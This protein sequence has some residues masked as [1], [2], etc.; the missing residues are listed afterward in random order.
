MCL[1]M[2]WRRKAEEGG[3]VG[4]MEERMFPAGFGGHIRLSVNTLVVHGHVGNGIIIMILVLTLIV[5][6][7]DD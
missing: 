4:S 7:G 6:P 2:I 1:E 5:I 3:G